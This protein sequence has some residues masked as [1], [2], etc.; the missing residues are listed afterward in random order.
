MAKALKKKNKD[1]LIADWKDFDKSSLASITR[2]YYKEKGMDAFSSAKSSNAIP[3][4]TSCS[5]A[6]AESLVLLLKDEIMVNS[7][8]LETYRVMECGVGSGLFSYNFLK[9][10]KAHNILDKIT[11]CVCDFD[12]N[13]LKKIVDVGFLDKYTSN[14]EYVVVDLLNLD[15]AFYYDTE[16][17]FDHKDLNL[18]IM[19]YVLDALPAKPVTHSLTAKSEFNKLQ[20]KLS[21]KS[22]KDLDN[23]ILSND[24]FLK[25]LKVDKKYS[26]YI[27]D[28]EDEVEQ[29]Y[30]SLLSTYMKQFDPRKQKAFP[31]SYG[32]I[33]AVSSIMNSLD[34]KGLL[35][36]MDIPY[37]ENF[38]AGTYEIFGNTIANLVNFEIITS[39]VKSESG[40]YRY[41]RNEYY[42]R[43]LVS[44][45][46]DYLFDISKELGPVDEFM[47]NSPLNLLSDL[48][49]AIKT[50]N[51]REG[52]KISAILIDE[53]KK[54]TPDSPY[55]YMVES[56][57]YTVLKEYDKAL[58]CLY[59]ALELDITK[60]FKI[61]S[62]ISRVKLLKNG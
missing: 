59:T 39:T 55:T 49:R 12:A 44:K 19:N 28:Q 24:V 16:K 15:Q 42:G 41:R 25:Q 33:K 22:D 57:Y 9:A 50:I 11:Y 31:Y 20:V 10:A 3:A 51:T 4:Q 2:E 47:D 43:L 62:D 40:S 56:Q 34:D 7:P 13:I 29:K 58:E 5:Y 18:V 45:D 14:I 36:V 61:N 30:I 1:K 37:R 52:M 53:L 26:P 46:A 60:M 6:H 23:N 54:I 38:S 17:P 32:A 8:G 21:Q 48:I 35:Y 27:L